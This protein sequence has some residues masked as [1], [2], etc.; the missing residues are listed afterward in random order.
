MNQALFIFTEW[1][2][3]RL[4]SHWPTTIQHWNLYWFLWTPIV[5]RYR[6]TAI[7]VHVGTVLGLDI[8]VCQCEHTLIVNAALSPTPMYW[9]LSKT[10]QPSY[11]SGLLFCQ[12]P[13]TAKRLDQGRSHQLK[14]SLCREGWLYRLSDQNLSA[15]ELID[16]ILMVRHSLQYGC[17]VKKPQWIYTNTT[18]N[19][20]SIPSF[21]RSLF[22]QTVLAL[23]RKWPPIRMTNTVSMLPNILTMK[24]TWPPRRRNRKGEVL[25]CSRF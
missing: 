16:L 6:F 22:A 20:Y 1:G 25:F 3:L 10:C 14:S 2:E 4:C 19:W 8:G 21:V 11:S 13:Q 5:Y 18:F 24:G 7:T 15:Q 23:K 9:P 17:C 12:E